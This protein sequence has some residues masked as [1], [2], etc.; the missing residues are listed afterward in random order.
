MTIAQ[1]FNL[2]FDRWKESQEKNKRDNKSSNKC[3]ICKCGC[4]LHIDGETSDDAISDAVS[5]LR[6]EDVNL[7][8][9]EML[10]IDLRSPGDT[11]DDENISWTIEESDEWKTKTK[12][13]HNKTDQTEMDFKFAR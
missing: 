11:L 7:K 12:L 4:K 6:E 1:A 3:E 5:K 10:L 13:V 9:N 2:A 8:E